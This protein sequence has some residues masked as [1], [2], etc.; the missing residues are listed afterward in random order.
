MECTCI[1]IGCIGIKILS[2][3]DLEAG[4]SSAEVKISSAGVSIF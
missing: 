2:K 4:L 1:K 3:S